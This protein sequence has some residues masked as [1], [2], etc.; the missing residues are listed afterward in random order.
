MSQTLITLKLD[1]SRDLL[2]ARQRARQ[3]A[4]LLGFEPREQALIGAAVFEIAR[5]AWQQQRPSTLVF[6]LD[7]ETLRVF[8]EAKV[9]VGV[10][11][12]RRVMDRLLS[13]GLSASK[14]LL[15]LEKPLPKRPRPVS[16][17]DLPWTIQQLTQITPLNL[18]EEIQ[19]QNRELLG[20]YLE[21]QTKQAELAQIKSELRR[22]AAA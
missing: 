13:D 15:H 10:K 4:G 6:Q 19:Q 18:M 1:A 16:L 8:P 7:Q 11:M 21:L 3:L 22:P 2:A 9:E 17:E 20:V 5:A 12:T 14:T